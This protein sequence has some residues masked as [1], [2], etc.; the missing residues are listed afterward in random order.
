MKKSFLS[1]MGDIAKIMNRAAFS[2][3]EQNITKYHYGSWRTAIH[4]THST[5]IPSPKQCSI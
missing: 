3:V 2:D 1:R 5:T 4:A